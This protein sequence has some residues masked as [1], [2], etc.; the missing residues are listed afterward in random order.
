MR[1]LVFWRNIYTDD[2]P[3]DKDKKTAE[4]LALAEAERELERFVKV[5]ERWDYRI[6]LGAWR[7]QLRVKGD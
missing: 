7:Y 2:E 6:E 1:D 4:G 3:S 5:G